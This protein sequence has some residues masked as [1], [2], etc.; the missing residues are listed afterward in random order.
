METLW[1]L[2]KL[3][4]KYFIRGLTGAEEITALDSVEMEIFGGETF[5]VIGESG[6]GKTTLG[7]TMI[8]L[9]EPT[10][11]E[12]YFKGSKITGMREKEFIKLRR[13]FQ[14]VFQDPYRALNPRMAVGNAIM[15]GIREGAGRAQ[16]KEKAGH[17]LELVGIAPERIDDFPHQFSGGERQ[18]VAVARALSTS[19]SF[20]VCDEPTSNL[21]LSIQAKILNLFIEL[22]E[23]LNLTYLFISHNIKIIEFIADRVA[24]M[25]AGRI[26]EYGSTARVLGNPLHPYTKLLV[27][28]SFFKKTETDK[29]PYKVEKQG[30][31]FSR[32]CP[33]V[34]EICRKE[35][36]E[37]MPAEEGHFVACFG[38]T[39]NFAEY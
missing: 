15:E 16:K 37:L 31:P 17:M 20:M 18:R 36:P 1:K 13:S 27:A 9:V 10:S 34:R 8:R 12:I 5:G 29:I 4:K 33:D 32:L 26:A 25:Y 14:I 6:S 22:K 3:S 39:N 11:G 28:A 2:N 30:C 7:K 24:V 35:K 38:F 19:P 21:D 23:K